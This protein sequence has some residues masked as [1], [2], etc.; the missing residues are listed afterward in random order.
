MSV[1][2][3]SVSGARVATL[4]NGR[5]I[6]AKVMSFGATLLE[7]HAPDRAGEPQD[8]VLGFDDPAAYRQMHPYFGATV[9][10]FANRIAG[11]R[12]SLDG[13]VSTLTTN[14]GRNTLHGGARG[15]TWAEWELFR[16][17]S[18]TPSVSFRYRSP[19]GEEGFPGELRAEV[20]YTLTDD[21]ALRI[22]WNATTDAPTVVNLTQ[23][24]YWNLAGE[25][26]VCGHELQLFASRFLPVDD[27]LLPTGELKDVRGTPMDFLEPR[28]IATDFGAE[29]VQIVRAKGGF[30]HCWVLDNPRRAARLVEPRSGRV[31][32][33]STT[34]PG[35]QFYS[36]N[37]L[38][39]TIHGKR[40]VPYRKYGGLCLETQHFPDTPNRPSFPSVLF[41]PGE[42]YAHSVTYRFST[43]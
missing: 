43:L 40:G 13:Q 9:G 25:G 8:V 7:L 24:A 31:M 2:V 38:D 11:G 23:H 20:T 42:T 39:G 26:D 12:F 16:E 18:R 29:D 19:A 33:V 3:E 27:E 41:R 5:G 14:E 37:Q 17:R 6:R 22:E 32:E 10:R 15:F 34:Q 30:D 35:L 28:P 4:D 1:R 21:D 36:G